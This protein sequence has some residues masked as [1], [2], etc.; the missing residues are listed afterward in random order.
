MK[1]AIKYVF[2]NH[3]Q[4]KPNLYIKVIYYIREKQS[5]LVSASFGREIELECLGSP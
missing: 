1:M 4:V 2:N 5:H 3:P